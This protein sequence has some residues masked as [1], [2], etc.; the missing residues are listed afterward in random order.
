M[1]QLE[2][3]IIEINNKGYDTTN[4]E[5]SVLETL[6][7][8]LEATAR[9]ITFGNLD[10]MKS[11]SKNFI[12][13]EDGTTLIPPFRAIDGLGEV[14]A[15]NIC[16]E[17]KKKPFLSIEEFQ[18]RC[19]VSQTLVDKMKAMGLFGDLPETSQLSLF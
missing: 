11:D 6:K 1:Y 10:L 2:N 18:K 7:L 14:V 9:G 4:K 12:I 17:A 15:D 3:K 19:K 8:A 16:K 5:N 13:D